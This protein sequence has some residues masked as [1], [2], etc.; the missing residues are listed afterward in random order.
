MFVSLTSPGAKS[1]PRT[2][3]K[4]SAEYPSSRSA[5]MSA[6]DLEKVNR[7][8][9]LSLRFTIPQIRSSNLHDPDSQL[10]YDILILLFNCSKHI[11]EDNDQVELASPLPKLRG[12]QILSLAVSKRG[13][14]MISILNKSLRFTHTP[15][16]ADSFNTH[17][18][19]S[20]CILLSGGERYEILTRLILFCRQSPS[21]SVN[22]SIVSQSIPGS[23]F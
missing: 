10:V 11:K 18:C 19:L 13:E 12:L 15:V 9:V 14:N 22:R 1:L 6:K 17:Q 8:N 16:G 2:I 5:S 4:R 7:C 21:H 23:H 3:R 20:L